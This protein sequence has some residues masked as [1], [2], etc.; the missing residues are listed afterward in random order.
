MKLHKKSELM[1]SKFSVNIYVLYF[2][3]FYENLHS[4]STIVVLHKGYD[5]SLMY[6]QDIPLENSLDPSQFHSIFLNNVTSG[7]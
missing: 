4:I 1:I 3:Y 7:F 2:Y 6:V 5:L